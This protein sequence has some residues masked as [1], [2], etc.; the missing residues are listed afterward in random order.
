[1]IAEILLRQTTPHFFVIDCNDSTLS[2]LFYDISC[3]D[4]GRTASELDNQIWFQT[5]DKSDI[6]NASISTKRMI[7][8]I[9]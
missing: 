3:N 2:V 6:F 1:M 5:F 7:T 9:G 8:E 4:A